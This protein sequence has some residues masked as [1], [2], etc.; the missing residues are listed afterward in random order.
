MYTHINNYISYTSYISY[1]IVFVHIY[2]KWIF[3]GL[4][5]KMF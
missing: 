2:K 3:S 1:I 4:N 5:D